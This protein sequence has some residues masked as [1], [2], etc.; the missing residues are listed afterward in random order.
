MAWN[1]WDRLHAWPQLLAR[2]LRRAPAWVLLLL[3]LAC[4]AVG[5]VLILDPVVSL[6]R[7]SLSL[8]LGLVVSGLSDLAAGP[9]SPRRV[10]LP[11]VALCWVETTTLVQPTALPST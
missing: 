8:G 11:L 9:R 3:G 6:K 10:L 5:V 2:F 4:T 1:V 7:Y